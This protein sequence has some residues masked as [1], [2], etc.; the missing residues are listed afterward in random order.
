MHGS[1][2]TSP[3]LDFHTSLYTYHMV[4]SN[5]TLVNHNSV[6]LG[7]HHRWQVHRLICEKWA[8]PR[9]KGLVHIARACAGVSIATG[10]ISMVIYHGFCMMCSSM[11]DKRMSIRQYPVFSGVSRRM[12]LQ[13]VPHPSSS[14]RAWV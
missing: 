8:V 5:D 1:H 14:R 12:R 10:R 7:C 2:Y 6:Y 9:K 13:C 4:S 11:D 3:I